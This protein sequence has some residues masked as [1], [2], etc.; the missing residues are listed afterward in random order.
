M[1]RAVRW[2]LGLGLLGLIV[3]GVVMA[4]MPQPVDVDL[5][6]VVRGD[7]QVTIDED[8]MTRIRQR[9]TVSAPVAGLLKRIE[10]RPGDEIIGRSTVLATIEPSEPPILDE[11]QI[12]E[13]QAR[14]SAAESMIDRASANRSQSEVNKELAD[15]QFERATQLRSQDSMSQDEFD[16][17]QANARLREHELRSAVFDEQ[18]AQFE[19]QQ[20]QAAL[21]RIDPEL[22]QALPNRQFVIEAPVDGRVLRLFEESATIVAPGTPLLEVGNPGDLEI[23]VDVLSTDAVKIKKGDFVSIE[24]WGGDYPLNAVVRTVEPAA[25]TKI[26]ALGVEEQRVNII[27]DFQESPE[28]ISRLADGFRIEAKIVIAETDDATLIPA[29]ALFRDGDAW[30]VFV[31][32]DGVAHR[33]PI[34]IG[35]RNELFAEVLNGLAIDQQVILYPSDQIEDGVQL[36]DRAELD[37]S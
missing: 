7:L 20:A 13:A 12:A 29:S 11:R 18:I 3:F 21:H 34:E 9:Y 24:Q 35:L 19:L 17:A 27:A 26:S 15:R 2:I 36:R 5:A 30:F 37:A 23:V 25:F 1:V 14:V 32:A 8:G 28:R 31:A 33:T 16:S 4:M 6:K 22:Q 10:L